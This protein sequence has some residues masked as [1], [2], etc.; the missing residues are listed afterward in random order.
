MKSI[1]IGNGYVSPLDT[2]Y[3][4]YETL[5]T[6]KPGVAKPV[7]NQTR[8]QIIAE[9]LPR[10]IYVYEACYRYPDEVLCKA[11]DQVCEPIRQLFHNESYAGG[12][13]PFDSM[14][15]HF[16]YIYTWLINTSYPNLRSR[17][18]LL[19]SNYRYPAIH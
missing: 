1:L 9:A 10:C 4:Y 13:D 2:T 16:G 7:F 18:S 5:C 3:G 19:R 11:T 14:S 15:I 6:T 17:P 8:C 12:R